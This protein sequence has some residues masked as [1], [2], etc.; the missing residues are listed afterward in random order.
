MLNLQFVRNE[1]DRLS[2][3]PS[4]VAV[5]NLSTPQSRLLQQEAP[6]SGSFGLWGLILCGLVG[7]SHQTCPVQTWSGLQEKEPRSLQHD[8]RQPDLMSEQIYFF[9]CHSS[10]R[11]VQRG[12]SRE[13]IG[14]RH[15]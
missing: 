6:G 15:L 5:D 8:C 3:R 1:S 4:V 2:F 7:S 9:D 10:A 13:R 12:P 11:Q 14:K